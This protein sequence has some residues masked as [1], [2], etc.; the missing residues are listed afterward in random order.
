MSLHSLRVDPERRGKYDTG[1]MVRAF[2]EHG[3]IG[4]ADLGELDR[5][6]VLLCAK[7]WGA[8]HLLL[9]LLRHAPK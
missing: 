2:D 6:S 4:N 3:K 9:A 1:I 7:E 8:D 5:A